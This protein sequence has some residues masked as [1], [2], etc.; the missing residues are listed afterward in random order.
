MSVSAMAQGVGSWWGRMSCPRRASVAAA[1]VLLASG[2]AFV[3][4]SG[5]SGAVAMASAAVMDPLSVLSGRSPGARDAGSLHQTK[6]G[7]ARRV[8]TA[9]VLTPVRPAGP[10]VVP[11]A[12]GLPV[13]DA[14]VPAG[15]LPGV[16]VD[17]GLVP[18]VDLAT[19]FVGG[20]GFGP[21]VVGGGGLI[22]GGGGFIGGGG[23]GGGGVVTPPTDGV[24]TPPVDGG[25]P[26][27]PVPEPATWLSMI[28]GFAFVGASM[29]RRRRMAVA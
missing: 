21:G 3:G 9:R 6:P 29:R 16:P 5:P 27:S 26:V 1:A 17:T 23:G 28:V 10:D 2:A 22:G 20:G 11:V 4:V 7:M 14:D 18:P 25:T 8:P 15:F 13:I 19:P 12:P 24:V